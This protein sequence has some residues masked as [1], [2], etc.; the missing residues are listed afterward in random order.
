MWWVAVAY[1]GFFFF[2]FYYREVCFTIGCRLWCS[3]FWTLLFSAISTVRDKPCD[4]AYPQ[5]DRDTRKKSPGIAIRGYAP[6]PWCRPGC[7]F[8]NHRMATEDWWINLSK[9]LVYRT[10]INLWLYS[11]GIKCYVHDVYIYFKEK[12][13]SARASFEPGTTDASIIYNNKALHCALP[14]ELKRQH[15]NCRGQSVF[16]RAI[17]N[18]LSASDPF[19]H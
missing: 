6:Y 4:G 14:T 5:S 3:R 8:L 13:K 12:D 16:I 1:A 19:S 10:A 15:R 17:P 9:R 11:D 2:F 18:S 7:E